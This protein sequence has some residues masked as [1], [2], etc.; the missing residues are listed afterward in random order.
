VTRFSFEWLFDLLD[1]LDVRFVQMGSYP[2]IYTAEDGFFLDLKEKAKSR[3]VLIKSCF[4]TYRDLAGFLTGDPHL[5]RAARKIFERMIHV[6]ALVGA[7]STGGHGGSVFRDRMDAKK[8]GIEIFLAHMKDLMF[9]AKEK[10]LKALTIEPMSCLAEHPTLPGEIDHMTS[11]LDGHHGENP[12]TTVPVYLC[13]DIGHGYADRKHNIIH[14][15]WDLFEHAIPHASEF[16]FKNT[17]AV[18]A[19]TFGF[20]GDERERGIIDLRRLKR[21]LEDNARRFPVETVVGY[22]EISGPKIGRD[23]SDHQLER[24]IADSLESLKAAFP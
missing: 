19:A 7:D 15:N 11:V 17:D 20:A 23:Y 21:L 16:H 8:R 2:E 6:A 24:M 3:N 9:L 4:T 12:D 1:R 18:F 14:D 10:G 13:P 5:E 22:L